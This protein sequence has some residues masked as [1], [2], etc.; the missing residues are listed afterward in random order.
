MA[1]C[2]AVCRE[3]LANMDRLRDLF[4]FLEGDDEPQ[5]DAEE[6]EDEVAAVATPSDAVPAGRDAIL[7]D[8]GKP[9]AQIATGSG[10]TSPNPT[11]ACPADR[12]RGG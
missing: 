5:E 8:P 2:A 1:V 6:A 10:W 4:P 12:R 9:L 11:P 3:R 7:D